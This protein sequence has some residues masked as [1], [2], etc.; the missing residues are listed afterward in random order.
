M[1]FIRPASFLCV[2]VAIV[3]VIAAA[4]AACPT[5][6]P[7]S[8]AANKGLLLLEWLSGPRLRKLLSC[9]FPI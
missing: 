3:V 7:K 6:G 9:R 8:F 4:A 1:T 5:K 2:V